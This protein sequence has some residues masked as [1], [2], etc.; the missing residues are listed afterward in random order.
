M[1]TAL[2]SIIPPHS[3]GVPIPVAMATAALTTNIAIPPQPQATDSTTP[4]STAFKAIAQH[5][6]HISAQLPTQATLSVMGAGRA[7]TGHSTGA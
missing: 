7:T 2:G 4:H 5:A 6:A 1:T 3:I